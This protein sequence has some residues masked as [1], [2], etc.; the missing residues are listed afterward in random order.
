MYCYTFSYCVTQKVVA[1]FCRVYPVNSITT[2]LI[3]C[4]STHDL[5][6]TVWRILIGISS[7]MDSSNGIRSNLMILGRQCTT[8]TSNNILK[9]NIISNL[10]HFL[11]IANNLTRYHTH[12]TRLLVILHLN[13]IGEETT[14]QA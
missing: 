10:Y 2:F 5:C 7:I 6:W 12:M 8:I 13:L 11:Y 1:A 14:L 3:S 9:I 4:H